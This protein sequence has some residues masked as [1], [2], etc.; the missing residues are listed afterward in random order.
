[1][2]LTEWN[3]DAAHS[4][5]GFGVRH[6]MVSTVRG[7]FTNVTGKVHWDA[8]APESSKVHVEVDIAS[9]DT[10]DEKR[11]EHLKSADFFDAGTH[12]KMTFEST[13]ITKKGDDL[14]LAGNLTIKGVSK[15]VTFDVTEVTGEHADPWGGL[16]MGA[17]AK[18]KIKRSDFGISFNAVLDAGGVMVGDEIKI[19]LEIE[20]QRAKA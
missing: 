11:D 8:Q 7:A 3:V 14:Q 4:T 18:A 19:E 13:K 6:M 12:P 16:R 5:V 17:S 2:S 1:M 9:V 10:R 20:L 15:P